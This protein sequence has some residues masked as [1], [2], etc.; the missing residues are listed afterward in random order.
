MV[1]LARAKSNKKEIEAELSSSC[2]MEP[3]KADDASI[4]GMEFK[5]W[6]EYTKVYNNAIESGK[7]PDA[8]AQ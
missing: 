7:S 2:W 6:Q 3:D 4:E 5:A 8:A 1:D